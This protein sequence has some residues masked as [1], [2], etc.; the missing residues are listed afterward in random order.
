M[1]FPTITPIWQIHL[2]G[3][4]NI[5]TNGT[6]PSTGTLLPLGKK[7]SVI[8]SSPDNIFLVESSCNPRPT[9]RAWCAVESWAAQNPGGKVWYVMTSPYYEDLTGMVQK[10]LTTYP[11]L[12]IV[13]L[14][15]SEVFNGTPLHEFFASLKWTQNTAWPEIQLSDLMRVALVWTFGG[16]Y[17]DTDTICINDSSRLHNVIGFQNYQEIANGQFHAEPNHTFMLEIMKH[18]VKTY[19]PGVWGSL[20]PKC[21]TEVGAKLCGGPLAQK[22]KPFECANMTFLAP[23]AFFPVYWSSYQYLLEKNKGTNLQQV[24]NHFYLLSH[25]YRLTVLCGREL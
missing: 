7:E 21:F 16:Y 17:S 10:L 13:A 1:N 3:S 9:Y 4:R 6:S 24:Q 25:S 18:M 11:N 2:C 5:T 22:Q 20:G 19:E 12:Q 15:L 23:T 8:K 14:D